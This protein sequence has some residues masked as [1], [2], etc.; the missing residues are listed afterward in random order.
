MTTAEGLTLIRELYQNRDKRARQLREQGR[1]VVG[2]FCCYPSLE[3]MTAAGVVP[4]RIVGNIQEPITRAD[5]HLEVIVCGYARS[6]LDI[7]LKGVYD[8]FDGVVIPGTC[9]TIDKLYRIW[10]D[11]L[12]PQYYCHYLCIPHVVQP[13]SLEFFKAELVAFKKSMEKLTSIEIS[14]QRLREAIELCNKVRVLV[15]ELYELRKQDPPLIS[16]TE[17]METILAGM[18]IPMEEFRDMLKA[19]I[20][21]VKRR[22]NGP[23]KK[24]AR[25]LIYGT[26]LDDA[27]LVEMVE[28]SNANVVMDDMC[29]GTRYYWHDVGV[30]GDPLEDIAVRYLDKT[31]C[32]CTFRD[33]RGQ[34]RFQYLLDYARDFKVNGVI[35]AVSN[36][37]DCH[38]Y[39][40]PDV[41]DALKE[42]GLP[43]LYIQYDYSLTSIAGLRTRVEAFTESIAEMMR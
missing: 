32:P 1:K 29:L 23:E 20:E 43:F 14:D 8:F 27:A 34:Q 19:V 10:Q 36:F 5:T 2:Y 24:P 39:D 16:G 6:S 3:I 30:T 12:E 31:A 4:Y 28:G 33:E 22:R 15:R 18:S 42:A 21:E 11:V 9:E 40:V 17:V 38:E 35:L 26:E 13:S 37:C 25:L 41:R 7:A